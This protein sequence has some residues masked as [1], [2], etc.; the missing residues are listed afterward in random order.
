MYPLRTDL[1]SY[2]LCL[3]SLEPPGLPVA[4]Q[5]EYPKQPLIGVGAIIVQSGRVVLVK[6]GHAPLAG[7]WS[8]PGGVLEIGET[9]REGVIREAHEET[10][11]AIE[12]LELLGVFD[13]LTRDER[14][15]VVYHYVLVDF[16]CRV[17]GGDLK[18]ADDAVE[19]CWFNSD[20]V[21]GLSLP[22]D[23]LKAVRQGIE[24]TT[25]K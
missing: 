25:D 22:P 13:R 17:V 10:G 11:L 2:S 16:L 9:M 20:E 4:E 1:H 18:A 7:E 6:R 12:P 24:K 21:A 3:E 15:Q 5:R 19:A 8:I 14:G 23:T